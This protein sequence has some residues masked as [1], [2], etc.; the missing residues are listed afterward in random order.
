MT[1]ILPLRLDA[2]T[3]PVILAKQ[4]GTPLKGDAQLNLLA[5]MPI[6]PNYQLSVATVTAAATTNGLS[7]ADTTKL[8]AEL[9]RRR[10]TK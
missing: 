4:L 1:A 8:T 3:I 9:S 2:D 5:E 6:H 7:G 10:V